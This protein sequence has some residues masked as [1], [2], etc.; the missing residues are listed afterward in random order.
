MD[1]D[2]NGEVIVVDGVYMFRILVGKF[3]F[4]EFDIVFFLFLV[5]NFVIIV[6]IC[7]CDEGFMDVDMDVY[8]EIVMIVNI[9][10]SFSEGIDNEVIN[11]GVV[12]K[13]NF[14]GGGSGKYWVIVINFSVFEN[15]IGLVVIIKIKDGFGN[16]V[17]DC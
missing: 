3:C 14:V 16:S 4:V 2:G 13:V 5:D 9:G 6:S 1:V 8:F 10:M 11:S 17:I 12:V 7:D 15:D